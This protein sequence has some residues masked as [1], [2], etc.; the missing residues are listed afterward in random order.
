MAGYRIVQI[1]GAYFGI[2]SS[3]NGGSSQTA[4]TWIL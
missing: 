1:T 4:P 3:V 2:N